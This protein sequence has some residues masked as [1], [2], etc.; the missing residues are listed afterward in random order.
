MATFFRNKVVNGLGT[1][2]TTLIESQPASR[3]TVIG[4]SL[5][6]L[7]TSVVKVSIQVTDAT[8]TT[9]YYVKDVTLPPYQSLRIVNGGE[10]LIMAESNALSGYADQANAVD[11]VISYVE[12]V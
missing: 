12:I 10:K 3:I 4:M 7:L 6:N 5:C 8:S 9:G 2:S 1:V 11:V